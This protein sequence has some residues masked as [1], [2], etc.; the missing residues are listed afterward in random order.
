ME[1]TIAP[2]PAGVEASQPGLGEGQARAHQALCAPDRGEAGTPPRTASAANASEIIAATAAAHA[3]QG[4]AAASAPSSVRRLSSGA[5]SGSM[6]VLYHVF[7]YLRIVRFLPCVI[8]SHFTPFC[9]KLTPHAM[10]RSLP[11]FLAA[12]HVDVASTP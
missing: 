7:D 11:C 10:A 9:A 1:N 5:L 2:P 4:A 6:A 3:P 8:R 12:F